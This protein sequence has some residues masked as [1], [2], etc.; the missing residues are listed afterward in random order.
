MEN[1]NT[2]F[3]KFCKS[4]DN[5]KVRRLDIASKANII[6]IFTCSKIWHVGTC[7]PMDTAIMVKYVQYMFKYIWNN[8]IS[9]VKRDTM[10][11]NFTDGGLRVVDIVKKIYSFQIK[12][13]LSLLYGNFCKW[14]TFAIYWIGLDLLNF[15]ADFGRSNI[16]H[17]VVPSP[18]Y[19][20][21]LNQF[22]KYVDKVKVLVIIM[23]L[24]LKPYIGI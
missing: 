3:P 19:N 1:H 16:P 8:S 22:S 5:L 18:Y 23:I 17:A 4:I 9:L 10:Y 21:A 12:H 6:N 24:K 14:H 7:I 15:N 13:I 20:N 2:L 11:L